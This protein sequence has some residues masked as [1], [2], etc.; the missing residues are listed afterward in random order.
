MAS[1]INPM[2]SYGGGRDLQLHLSSFCP[3]PDRSGRSS[4]GVIR[5]QEE[6]R[7]VG[8]VAMATGAMGLLKKTWRQQDFLRRRGAPSSHLLY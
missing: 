5:I 7:R 4:P 8:L 1:I 3:G 6:Q 2:I